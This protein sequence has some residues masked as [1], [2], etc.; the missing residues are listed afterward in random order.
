MLRAKAMVSGQLVLPGAD[1]VAS[2]EA[3]NI[4]SA[5]VSGLQSSGVL[6]ANNINDV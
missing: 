1:G 4:A 6:T 2:I 3:A 5:V